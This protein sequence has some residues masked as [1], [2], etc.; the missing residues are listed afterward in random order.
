MSGAARRG[1]A[2]LGVAWLF[3]MMRAN[4][5]QRGLL[6]VRQGWAGSG[7]ASFGMATFNLGA[8]EVVYLVWFIGVS[9]C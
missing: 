8:S 5:S 9:Q 2:R 3:S 6:V 4:R 7:A 1:A